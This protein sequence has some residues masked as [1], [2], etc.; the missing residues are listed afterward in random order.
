MVYLP[1][2]YN[3][4]PIICGILQYMGFRVIKDKIVPPR[5]WETLSAEYDRKLLNSRNQK[6]QSIMEEHQVG[7][8]VQF[9]KYLDTKEDESLNT[10][11]PKKK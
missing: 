10:K 11:K 7:E 1:R 3:P 6:K 2:L 5:Q 4:H 8:T 9:N